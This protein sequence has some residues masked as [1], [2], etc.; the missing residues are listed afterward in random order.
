[1][2]ETFDQKDF[3]KRIIEELQYNGMEQI[4][5]AKRSYISPQMLNKK[6]K[7][8]VDFKDDEIKAITKILGLN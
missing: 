2:T 8:L 1:M 3:S 5:L 7:G 4:E 6:V